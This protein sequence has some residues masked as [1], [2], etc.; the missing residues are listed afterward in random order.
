MSAS[1]LASFPILYISASLFP[2]HC[3][4]LFLSLIIYFYTSLFMYLFL[5]PSVSP[6]SPLSCNP[7]SP[8][9]CLF[10]FPCSLTL[11]LLYAT[12][13][14]LWF[15]NTLNFLSFFFSRFFS[16][17]KLNREFIFSALNSHRSLSE[18]S[19]TM[20]KSGK[21]PPTQSVLPKKKRC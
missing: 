19:V 3:F 12:Q 15:A 10:S 14:F 1:I 5:F 11:T 9:S 21:R 13:H 20:G 7:A 16:R 17:C 18:V 6:R 4:S 8:T 2:I